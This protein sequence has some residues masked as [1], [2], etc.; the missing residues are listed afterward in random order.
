MIWFNVLAAIAFMGCLYKGLPPNGQHGLIILVKWVA[1]LSGIVFIV[2]SLWSY[3]FYTLKGLPLAPLRPWS[4]LPLLQYSGS[5]DTLTNLYLWLFPLTCTGVL[6]MALLTPLFKPAWHSIYGEAHWASRHEIKKMG[7]LN[8]RGDVVIGKLGNQLLRYTLTNHL[9]VFAPSRSGKGV[10]LVIPNALSWVGSLLALDNKYEVFKYTSGYREA[11]GNKVYRF[12]PANKDFQTHC[13]N[14][15]DYVDKTNPSKRINDLQ[16][17]L[18]IL[19]AHSGD[20]NKMWVEEARSLALGLLLW[21]MQSDRLFALSELSAIVKGGN[22]SEFA[23]QIIEDNTIADNLITIDPAAYLA[24]QNFLQKAPKE[25]SGVRTTIASMLRL[26]EDPLICAATNHSDVDFRDMRKT[27]I[28]LYLSF[29]TNQIS[30]L[31]PLINLIIQLFLNIMLAELP[32][33]DEPH[34][35]LCLLDEFTRFGRMDKLK[36]GFGD[37]AGYGVHLIPIIQNLGQF[38]SVYGSRDNSDIFFQNTDV[39]IGFRQNSPTDKEFLSKELGT[40]T[41]RI[42]N[43]SYATNREGSNY[44]E[45]LIERPLQTPAQIARFPKK[46]QMIMTGEGVIRCNKIIYYK[47]KAFKNKL[48]A[49]IVIPTVIPQ[50]P[51]IDVKKEEVNDETPL[52][53]PP[54]KK[55]FPVKAAGEP[56][57]KSLS[58]LMTTFQQDDSNPNLLRVDRQTGEILNELANAF[59]TYEQEGKDQ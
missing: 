19:I 27:P 43:R 38:Y 8:D 58:S 50:F 7:F 48:L 23:T 5:F 13:I 18:D 9:L 29:G 42:K 49:A 36:D 26:W 51:V 56:I 31:S 3:I 40:Q 54:K 21:L 37:L 2:L 35:A 59:D 16:L 20:E 10:A 44:S 53:E 11:L 14:P 4:V 22:L 39:K 28:T 15:L 47:D 41:I 25:Q 52:I 24:I 12:S 57:E 34:K 1:F 32:S 55:R 46:K 6:T 33:T 30:L 45:S 17:I